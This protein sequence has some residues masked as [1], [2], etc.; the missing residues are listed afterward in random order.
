MRDAENPRLAKW[1]F[2]LADLLLLGSAY[3]VVRQGA[4]PLDLWRAVVIVAAVA[5]GGY[6]SL[7]PFLKE[8]ESASRLAEADQ[9]QTVTNQMNNLEVLAE[10]ITTATS[11]WQAV[12]EASE[13]IVRQSQ[14]ISHRMTSE[15]KAFAEF[16]KSA[17]DTEKSTL[18][19]EV[20]KLRRAEGDWLQV[21]VHTLDHIFAL[22]QSGMRSGQPNLIENLTNFQN[23]CRDVSRR[24]GLGVYAASASE[25]F[26][27]KR[28]QLAEGDP[29]QAL[30]RPIGVTVA[31]GY[32]LQGRVLRP[33]LVQLQP[34]ETEPAAP[35]TAPTA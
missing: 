3:L 19:L 11:R 27:P 34:V 35:E 22:H 12:Q 7:L 10:Q 9:L 20:E 8:Y 4:V 25:P 23:A 31:P 29:A 5:L 17:N 24:V 30:G 14:E 1:P 33:A 6:L 16:M 18:R 15:A 32:T 21:Q 26:D 2:F 28:H 13:K